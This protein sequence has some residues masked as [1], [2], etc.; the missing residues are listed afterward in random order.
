MATTRVVVHIGPM[1]TGTTAL[2]AYFSSAQSAGVLPA[3]V[4]YPVGDLWFP[5]SGNI[6]KHGQLADF[7]YPEGRHN[8]GRKTQIRKPDEVAAKL[9]D[10]AGFLAT[11][12]GP[13]ATAVF[14]SETLEG[15]P[16]VERLVELLTATFDEV[17]LVL[18]V[19]SPIEAAQ[20]LLV[21]KIKDWRMDHV[22]FDLFG[23]LKNSDG[24][25]S[26]DYQRMISRFHTLS[27]IE[28][29]LIPY[30]EE[31]S[32]GY[33]VVDRF[34]RIV[35]GHAAPR[36][37][38]DFGSRRIHPS[39]PLSSLKRLV[40]LKKLKLR[41]DRIPLVSSIIHSLFRRILTADRDK[42][43]R[44]GFSTRSSDSGD[45]VISSEDRARILALYGNLGDD[46][47]K[48]LGSRAT[49]PEWRDWFK[50]TG[51]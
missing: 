37:G 26:Y 32:D 6:T 46:L 38:G 31:E 35:T 15:R 5:A 28:F 25:L 45:W 49:Q 40:A 4:V 8:S 11:H 2:G 16:H 29:V 34:M 1:K 9:R 19:R 14:I 33:A 13:R 3:D 42:V 21:H 23:M 48:A 30:F 27:T 36:I 51:L 17:V 18:A 20:S 43:V 7:L 47:R 24:S 50:A 39:L 12:K 22:D 44:A 10:V 41:F